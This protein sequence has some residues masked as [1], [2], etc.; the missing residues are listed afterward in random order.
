MPFRSGFAHEGHK[1]TT[2][3]LTFLQYLLTGSDT[4]RRKCI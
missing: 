1:T 3:W 2:Y 4:R